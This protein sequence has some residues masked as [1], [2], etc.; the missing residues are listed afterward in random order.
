[1]RES[2]GQTYFGGGSDLLSSFGS[3]TKAF[4]LYS[5]LDYK[6]T[7]AIKLTF[8]ARYTHE[9]KDVIRYFRI[10]FDAASSI[11]SP[12]VIANIP[13]G[14]IPDAK[15]NNFSPAATLSYAVDPRVNVYARFARGFKSGGF[16][17]ESN[18]FAAPT[19]ACPTGALELCDPYKPEKVDSYELGLKT[20]LLDNKL[21]FNVAAFRDEHKDIQLSIFT[22]GFGATSVV[23][24]AAAARIQGLE[25]ETVIRPVDALTIN[26]SLA[27]LDAKYKSFIDGGVDVSNNRAFPHAPKATASAGVDWRALQG[28]WGKLNVYG[29]VSY[30]AKYYTFPYALT[31]PTPSDQNAH[32][33]ESM[34]RTIVNLR[35]TISDIDVGRAKMEISA[36]VRNLTKEKNPS[37]FIDFGPGFGGLTLGYFPDPR[38][39]G[40]TAGVK[41]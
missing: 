6:L 9:Q 8:G 24:N 29:D 2:F 14:A 23:R 32:N 3:H 15:Y 37:N 12:V 11:T 13:Y 5:Q 26:G 38:T 33:S 20:R 30:V 10:N 34:G 25:F 18:V 40:V 41:F 16:N 1:V 36:F 27:I 7:D 28:G 21:I 4:A 35:A 17:G 19:V 22:A 31:T 39:F